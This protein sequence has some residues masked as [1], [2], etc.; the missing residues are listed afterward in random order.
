M[1][2]DERLAAIEAQPA[3]ASEGEVAALSAEL[4][5]LR[6]VHEFVHEALKIIYIN[7]KEEAARTLVLDV[8]TDVARTAMKR[9][10][11]AKHAR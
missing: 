4:R 8:V 10:K 9:M 11:A 2:S 3:G 1:V 5:R 7:G 6:T